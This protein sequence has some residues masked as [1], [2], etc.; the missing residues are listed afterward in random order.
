MKLLYK[1]MYF[2]R[3]LF[4]LEHKRKLLMVYKSSG[5]SGTGHGGNIIPFMYLNSPDSKQSLRDTP[6]YIYKEMMYDGIFRSHH[7][8]IHHY[9]NALENMKVIS[10][11]LSKNKLDIYDELHDKWFS[12][13][14]TTEE[15]YDY[16]IKTNNELHQITKSKKFWDL[17]NPL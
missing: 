6:G 16:I 5:L 9:P 11:Y 17:V 3:I 10:D 15:L 4:I 1:A 12:E 13:A 7:K 8:K 14:K 2:G